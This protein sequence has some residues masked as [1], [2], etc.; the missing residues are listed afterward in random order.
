MPDTDTHQ[1]SKDALFE[2]EALTWLPHV[3]R[4][5][6]SL[7]R[8][9]ADADDLV[10]ETFL[11]AYSAWDTYEPGTGGRS[12]LFTICRNV[13]LRTV[14]RNKRVVAYDDP[15]AEAIASAGL[16]QYAV[17][18]GLDVMFDRIELR[19]ALQRSIASLPDEYRLTIVLIELEDCSY[20]QAAQTL[21]I[22]MGTVRSRLFRARRLLQEQLLA[23]AEDAG[24]GRGRQAEP[25]FG[26]TAES[27]T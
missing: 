23:F 1:L 8:D 21:N 4:F 10:Q 27:V 6:Q 12:W 7:A 26:P 25:S 3:A 18:R 5:A 11:R 15:E 22:P 2:R 14:H 20:A 17:Q 13:H 19:D 16:Y 24:Y 9:P